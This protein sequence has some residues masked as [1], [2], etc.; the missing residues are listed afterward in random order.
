MEERLCGTLIP[1]GLRSRTADEA[2]QPDKCV[3][4]LN[5]GGGRGRVGPNPGAADQP[6]LQLLMVRFISIRLLPT[7]TSI[8]D[9]W[10]RL[11]GRN[12]GLNKAPRMQIN[13]QRSGLKAKYF[14]K[15]Q[16]NKGINHR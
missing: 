13:W 11:L 14:S 15:R 10:E 6:I 7:L 9:I 1:S 5:R 16:Q 3:L 12:M 8:I 2:A 4:S